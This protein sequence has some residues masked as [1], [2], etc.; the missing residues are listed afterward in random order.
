MIKS[1]D[2][3]VF[4][5]IDSFEDWLD[6]TDTQVVENTIYGTMDYITSI[7]DTLILCFKLF[8]ALHEEAHDA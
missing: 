3:D 5:A 2:R 4:M 1:K 8:A 6:E 7:E